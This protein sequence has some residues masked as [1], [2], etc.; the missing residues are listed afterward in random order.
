MDDEAESGPF[1][2]G[3]RRLT[4]AQLN[5]LSDAV[6]AETQ[7]RLEDEKAKR[8]PAS[9]SDDEFKTWAQSLMSDD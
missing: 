4:T 7:R 6:H 1:E 9:M 2:A 5:K 8:S 3:L